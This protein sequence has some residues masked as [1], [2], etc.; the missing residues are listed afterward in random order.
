MGINDVLRIRAGTMK[1]RPD[2]ASE[3]EVRW[4]YAN[5]GPRG[6]GLAMRFTIKKVRTRKSRHAVPAATRL[7]LLP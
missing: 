2:A 5:R 7:H 4:D 3:I 1:D 6:T